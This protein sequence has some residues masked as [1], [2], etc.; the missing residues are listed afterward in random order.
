MC[1]ELRKLNLN[2]NEIGATLFGTYM[3]I[4]VTGASKWLNSVIDGNNG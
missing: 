1:V 4:V 2:L 3:F